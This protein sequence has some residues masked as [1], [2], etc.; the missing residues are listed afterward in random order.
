[1]ST[2]NNSPGSWKLLCIS[3][4]LAPRSDFRR[5]NNPA[6]K[7]RAVVFMPKGFQLCHTRAEP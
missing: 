1:M 4:R 2:R 5:P 6:S 7:F 3:I